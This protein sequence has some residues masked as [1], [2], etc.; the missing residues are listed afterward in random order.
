MRLLSSEPRCRSGLLACFARLR[1][2]I[3]LCLAMAGGAEAAGPV[4]TLYQTTVFVTGQ[5]A[6]TRGPGLAKALAAVLVKVSGDPRLAVDPRVVPLA[7]NVTD[8]IESFSYRDRMEGIPVHDEQGSRDRPYD[9][10]VF[11]KPAA[12]ASALRSL[13]SAPWTGPR[14]ELLVVV[15]VEN[16]DTRFV[17]AVDG[18]KGRDMREAM[19]AAAE[20]YGMPV[21]LPTEAGLVAAGAS[22][23]DLWFDFDPAMLADPSL[24]GGADMTLSGTLVWNDAALGWEADWQMAVDDVPYRWRAYQV[25]FDDAFRRAISGAA[26]I[27]SG[28]G[29]PN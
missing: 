21:T 8:F 17:L 6:E 16:G 12:I 23:L 19:A 2:A 11:F 25:S 15:A 10:T 18:A 5:S 14:P 13:G 9:L 20:Q 29:A 3:A 27:L 22:G 7:V 1:I 28:H 4:G 26:Q 24:M